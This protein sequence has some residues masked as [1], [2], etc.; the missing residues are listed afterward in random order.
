MNKIPVL[1]LT[2]P[3]A[4]GK[5]DLSI[6]LA[7]KLNAE[8]ISSDSMQIYKYMDI[9]SAKITKEEM[10]GV[11][12]H[13]IDFVDPSKE[14]SVSEFKDCAE[15]AIEDIHS[16]GKLPLITGGT[17]LY[18][19]S[20]IYDMGFANVNSDSKIRKELEELYNK[21]GK[22]YMHNMLR[23]MS[24]KAADKIHPNNVIRVIRAIEICKLGGHIGDFS[25]DLKLNDKFDC[26]IVV[27]NR[28][29]QV[30]YERI[31]MR[32]DIMMEKGLIKEVEKLYEMGYGKELTSMKGIGY[33]EV[34]DYLDGKS[35]LEQAIDKIKQG[36][37]R[38]AKRQITWFKRYEN[39]TWID[40]DKIRDID[41]QINIIEEKLNL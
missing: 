17:G 19:N 10:D 15:R 28:D 40:L 23:S 2:G 13:V 33:K 9:G 5:T 7:K 22:E 35:T 11:V 30:L 24:E 1:I 34:I 27:L 25:T 3:T 16:R 4:V 37:R 26:K 39:A 20:I 36:T 32:V 12:H 29:R 31:N 21:Y 18:L 8:I 41:E 38:Y 14:Y 6:K